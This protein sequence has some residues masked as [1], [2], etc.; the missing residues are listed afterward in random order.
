LSLKVFTSSEK[1]P[2]PLG[3]GMTEYMKFTVAAA[4]V[5]KSQAPAG[6]GR[7]PPRTAPSLGAPRGV[8][9]RC[10]AVTEACAAVLET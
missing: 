1:P 2:A 8:G 9:A 6:S 10:R 7:R 3:Q 4:T 5:G